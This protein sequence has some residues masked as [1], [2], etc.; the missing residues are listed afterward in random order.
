LA[1]FLGGI[2]GAMR[3]NQ[4]FGAYEEYL[5]NMNAINRIA[6]N[7]FYSLDGQGNS[8]SYFNELIS[9]KEQFFHTIPTVPVSHHIEVL[10]T[11]AEF[12]NVGNYYAE[13]GSVNIN[14]YRI[15]FVDPNNPAISDKFFDLLEARKKQVMYANNLVLE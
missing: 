14:T 1:L 11:L 9:V 15:P 13:F 3:A 7:C 4:L 5:S 6:E 8:L 12:Y 10:K 2:T